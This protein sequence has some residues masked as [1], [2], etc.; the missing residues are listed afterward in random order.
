MSGGSQQTS[1][2]TQTPWE[3][4]Q[5]M[6][7]TGIKDATNIYKS[8][9]AFKPYTGST[10]VPFAD[11]TMG[12]MN[13]I[14]GNAL[15]AIESGS[16]DKPMNFFGSM[17]DNG[18]LSSDQRGVADQ[19]RNTASGA[20]LENLP[21]EFQ[22]VLSRSLEDAGTAANLGMSGA[23]RYGSGMH[24]D[25]LGDRLGRVASEA[26]LGE[27]GRQQGRMDTARTNLAGLGQQGI[28]NQFGAAQGMPG[29]WDTSQRPATDLMKVGGM[30]EDLAGRTMADQL[31]IF[32]ETQNA[33]REAVEWLSAI[34]NGTGSLGGTQ[35]QIQPGTNP[36]VQALGYGLGANSLLGNPLGG[37]FGGGL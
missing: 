1:T 23:G 31:R 28:A 3:P 30:Y 19:W 17:L 4:A 35:R 9:E 25:V 21:P 24:M 34:G 15:G 22:N 16:M 14:Q 32:E 12:G 8:G 10:V 7:K 27:Y 36:F 6:L 29:A 2:A 18:G 37:L 20:E 26:R 5:G 33:P 11:Q 13:A